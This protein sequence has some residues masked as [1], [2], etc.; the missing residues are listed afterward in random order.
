MPRRTLA[1]PQEGRFTTDNDCTK[2][3]KAFDEGNGLVGCWCVGQL[4]PYYKK[5]KPHHA[6]A[7][8]VPHDVWGYKF[9]TTGESVTTKTSKPRKVTK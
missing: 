7:Q 4:G 6:C 8:F 2:C 1:T 5:H 9:K 3:R